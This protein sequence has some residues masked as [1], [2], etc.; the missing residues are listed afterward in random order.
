M[1]V[2]FRNYH[3]KETKEEWKKKNRGEPVVIII[4]IYMEISQGISLCN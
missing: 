1:N 2:E 3:K 4:H